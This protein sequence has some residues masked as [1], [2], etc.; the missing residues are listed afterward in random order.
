MRLFNHCYKLFLLPLLLAAG[1]ACTNNEP[2]KSSLAR[3]QVERFDWDPSL[4]EKVA[5][6]WEAEEKL[7]FI[8]P[9]SGE[10]KRLSP[11]SASGVDA[12]Y[13]IDAPEASGVI[14]CVYPDKSTVKLEGDDVVFTIPQRQDGKTLPAIHFGA[15][16]YI[17]SSYTPAKLHLE[18]LYD[19]YK[20][21]F[22]KMPFT[23]T[24]ILLSSPS[25]EL[26]SGLCRK[27]LKT[28]EVRASSASIEIVPE[29]PIDMSSSFTLIPV[30][31]PRSDFS[32]GISAVLTLTDGSKYRIDDV[33]KLRELAEKPYEIGTSLDINSSQTDANIK[34]IP[35]A[36]I[37]WVEVTC[38]S[39]WRNVEES[40]WR[41]KAEA[42]KA[43]IEKYHLKVWSCHLP[44][45]GNID[46]SSPDENKRKA[47]VELQ[48][49]M[50]QWCVELYHPKKLVLHPSTEPIADVDRQAHL[51]AARK[52]VGELAPVAAAAGV[53]LCIE[54]LPRTCLGRIP[55]ELKYIIEP[56]PDVMVTFDTNHLLLTTH[57]H[58]FEVLGDRIGNVHISDYD[59]EDERHWLPGRGVID[60]PALHFMLRSSGYDGIY[61]HEVKASSGTPQQ[62][63]DSYWNLIFGNKRN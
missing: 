21:M 28:G 24:S 12:L 27:D 18:P 26:I 22:G 3:V 1:I 40:K 48:K 29:K 6:R 39:F 60:W 53:V 11:I 13:H 15:A 58:Y 62:I 16:D 51:D 61:M 55:E 10:E 32:G 59:K 36:G 8:F 38:N 31:T 52:S 45:S 44:Y 9:D 57:E 46:I 50:I 25:G 23:V 30:M 5:S 42:I 56:Y 49:Q 63:V 7:C 54:N 43:L 35:A 2:Q 34:R 17:A 4:G 41:T 19:I 20:L 37:E 47:T 14:C 33:D